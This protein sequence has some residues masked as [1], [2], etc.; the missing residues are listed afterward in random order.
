VTSSRFCCGYLVGKI[1]EEEIQIYDLIEL[2]LIL[3]ENADVSLPLPDEILAELSSIRASV[4]VGIDFVGVFI[5]QPE[6][7]NIEVAE[8]LL[9]ILKTLED[10]CYASIYSVCLIKPSTSMW[11]VSY[12]DEKMENVNDVS[13]N[14][15]ELSDMPVFRLHQDIFVEWVT[16]TGEIGFQ[17]ENDLQMIN[18]KLA[19]HIENTNFILFDNDSG[20]D[21]PDLTCKDIIHEIKTKCELKDWPEK[22]KNGNIINVASL[23]RLSLSNQMNNILDDTSTELD[24]ISESLVSKCNVPVL[25]TQKITG[26]VV[27]L[28]LSID[29][30]VMSSMDTGTQKLLYMF[31][32][33]IYRQHNA[34]SF[35]IKLSHCKTVYEPIHFLPEKSIIPITALLPKLNFQAEPI[36]ETTYKQ[37]RAALHER[38]LIAD[39]RPLLRKCVSLF[40]PRQSYHLVNPHV[41]LTTPN[42]EGGKLALVDGKYAYHHYMQ[43]NFDDNIWGCAYRSLQTLAS[44]FWYQGYTDKVFPT[45]QEIQEALVEIGDKEKSFIGSHE[46]IG[47]MEVSYCLDQLYGITSKTLHVS[48]G[49]DLAYKGRELYQ[50]FIEQGTP[51]MIGGGVLA[52][53]IVGVVYNEQ[54]G[55]VRFLIVDPHYTGHDQLKTVQSKGWVGWKGPDFWN[56]TAHY[57]L[58]MPQRPKMI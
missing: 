18:R 13:I 37:Y 53:S 50:H 9:K 8:H 55:D 32:D 38:F 5:T 44:W 58:C 15:I 40:S 11:L 52:H 26:D 19:F 21:F 6:N 3:Y 49:A 33:A 31:K 25:L 56:K 54:T 16:S 48:T 30:L 4:P 57:N 23:T 12:E 2:N 29:V 22:R 1:F 39:D 35:L 24:S 45:H 46:W 17:S 10:I 14:H 7:G 36:D 27:S 43:D 42:I 34:L 47:S 41:G 20:G 28:K 51:I